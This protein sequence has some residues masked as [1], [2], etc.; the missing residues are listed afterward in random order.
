MKKIVLFLA[1]VVFTAVLAFPQSTRRARLKSAPAP[2][3]AV[4]IVPSAALTEIG[5][6]TIKIG[7]TSGLGHLVTGREVTAWTSSTPATA[8]VDPKGNVTGLA[9]GNAFITINPREYIAI[10]VVPQEDFFVVPDSQAA[11]L[12]AGS[13]MGAAINNVT[14]YKTEPT[15]RLAYRFN[16]PG[17]LKGLSGGNGGIDIIGRGDNY[18]WLWTTYCQGGWFYDLNGVSREMVN[19]YQSDA[20]SGVELTVKPEFIYD[21]GVPYLQ[22][23]HILHNRN[24]APVSG[25]RFGAS[26][27]IMIH[28][29]DYASLIHTPYGAYMAD[30]ETD[31]SLE[32]M[33]VGETAEGVTPVDTLWLGQWSNG[34]HIRYIY[35]DSRDDVTGLDSAIGFSYQNIDLAANE[36]REFIVRFTLARKEILQ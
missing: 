28:S 35:E 30:S 24:N 11:P 7:E 16:N 29:N 34:D 27:D 10:A 15:F 5:H 32:L 20:A 31:P 2:A 26:A 4:T 18:T 23:R 25:Q 21:Q 36:T 19:G 13:G 9:L 33:F 3:G 22:L 12:P 14:E 8:A 6:Y 17:E 1:L